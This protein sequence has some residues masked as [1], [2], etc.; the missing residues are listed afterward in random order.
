MVVV[1]RHLRN[2]H[3]RQISKISRIG[4]LGYSPTFHV[5]FVRKSMP[6]SLVPRIDPRGWQRLPLLGESERFLEA[7]SRLSIVHFPDLCIRLG[8]AVLWL[9]LVDHDWWEGRVTA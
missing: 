3:F 8:S 5:I 6:D 2:V 4:Q 1:G 7:A 9:R